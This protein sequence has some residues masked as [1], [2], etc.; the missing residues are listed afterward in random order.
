[1][2]K[3]QTPCTTDNINLTPREQTH[4]YE[5]GEEKRI[6]GNTHTSLKLRNNTAGVDSFRRFLTKKERRLH[7]VYT[8]CI[9]AFRVQRQES[10]NTPMVSEMSNNSQAAFLR[11][12]H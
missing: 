7:F 4:G 12:I 6:I 10:G 3:P 9:C 1:M 11:R 2:V 8:F 5:A